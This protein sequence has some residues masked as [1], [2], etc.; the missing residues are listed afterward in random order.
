MTLAFVT[1]RLSSAAGGLAAS[2]PS[3]AHAL[4][5]TGEEEVHVLGTRDPARPGEAGRW[6]PHVHAHDARG[7]AA[8][9]YAPGLAADLA[10]LRPDVVDV[11][12]LWTW[13]SRANLR[14]HRRTGTPY[15]VTPRGMLDPWALGNSA[16][17]KRLAWTAFEGA[18]LKGARAL[19][20]TAEMEAGHF[21]AIG[22]RSPVA[23][24][25][26]GIDIPA[27]G[28]RPEGP[29]RALFLS[30]LHPKKG[31]P[32]LLRAWKAVEAAQR[33]WE[34]VV[35]GIDEGGHEAEMKAL[36]RELRIARIAF[37]GPVHGAAKDALYR[38]ADLFVLPTHA[39]NFGL[40]VAEALA[41]EVP[42][43]TTRNAPWEG[44]GTHRCGWWIDLGE[45]QLEA[46]LAEAMS[47][48]RREL[49]AMGARGR[50]WMARD[51]GWDDVAERMRMVY[52][53]IL[54]GASRPDF[55]Q[56]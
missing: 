26:N 47:K 54:R 52:R 6:A 8:L 20:A 10:A 2:V 55:V 44:L 43:I 11:Q 31:L 4:A 49:H 32:I 30:R 5:R 35:A 45:P 56:D 22:L 16:W 3:L 38:S 9:H 18:H 7:P 29:R 33:D 1:S 12:G 27:L 34:L 36:A 21:R 28:P 46:A 14:H 19:R 24:V 41:Q 42:V 40:V 13:P 17:K 37:P 51:F 53:W 39:E 48:P 23:I 50:A 25:P 15:V